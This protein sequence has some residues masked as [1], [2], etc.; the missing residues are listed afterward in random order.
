[1]KRV[2]KE[3]DGSETV[4]KPDPAAGPYRAEIVVSSLDELRAFKRDGRLLAV[5]MSGTPKGR[6]QP[7]YNLVPWK[8]I[9]DFDWK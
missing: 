7:Q 8:Q 3:D 2:R 4:F 1:M 9:E 5:R 6:T